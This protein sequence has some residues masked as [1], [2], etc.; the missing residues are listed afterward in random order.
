MPESPPPFPRG[1]GLFV[2]MAISDK[3][4]TQL[5]G[6]IQTGREKAF[7]DWP[8]WQQLRAAVLALDHWECVRCRARGRYA[9]ARVVHHVRHLRDRPD[10][11]LS[12]W[13]ELP[14]GGRG[15]RQLVS[16]CKRCHED[17]HPEAL[18]PLAARRPPLT[19][20]RWD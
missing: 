13:L 12:V 19:P 8:E 17:E 2:F 9:R 7:Y 3:R 4:L 20:E 10:L 1:A 15:E 5:R 18:V 14:G 16:L 6:L 11:A